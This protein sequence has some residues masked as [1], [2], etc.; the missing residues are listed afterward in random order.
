MQ[1]SPLWQPGV[2][3]RAGAR[4]VVGVGDGPKGPRRG[5]KAQ[6][7]AELDRLRRLE[8]ERGRKQKRQGEGSQGEGDQEEKGEMSLFVYWCRIS[9]CSLQMGRVPAAERKGI[10]SRR[11]FMLQGAEAGDAARTNVS[12]YECLKAW[13]VQEGGSWGAVHGTEASSMHRG[14]AWCTWL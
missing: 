13:L 8:A 2:C 9:T 7:E 14:L 3:S 4:V 10:F 12:D 6:K 1:A 11:V 5:R